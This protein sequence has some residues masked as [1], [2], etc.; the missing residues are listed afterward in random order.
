MNKIAIVIPIVIVIAIGVGVATL[1][2]SSGPDLDKII[3]D[4][5][6]EAALQLSDADMEKATG[7]QQ[8]SI[9][10]MLTACFLN[11]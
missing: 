2:V 3:Q 9:G 7:E 8:L 11:G 5:D 1:S 4:Q 6:C 10:I